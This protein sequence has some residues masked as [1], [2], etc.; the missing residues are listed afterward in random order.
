MAETYIVRAPDK[1]STVTAIAFYKDGKQGPPGPSGGE[2]LFDTGAPANSLGQDNQIY[3]D[4]SSGDIYKKVSGAWVYQF[5]LTATP[6]PVHEL[7]YVAVADG[8]VDITLP[9]IN[10]ALGI[11]VFINGVREPQ[12]GF[13]FTATTASLPAGLDI[14]AGDVVHI[15]YYL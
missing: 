11:N 13:T 15:E 3:Y 8:A 5:T 1:F 14:I 6:A 7:E 12:N 10:T 4:G 9:N 2:W